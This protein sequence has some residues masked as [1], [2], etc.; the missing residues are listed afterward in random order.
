M[1]YLFAAVTLLSMKIIR[2]MVSKY[3]ENVRIKIMYIV[4]AL[5]TLCLV[6]LLCKK[7]YFAALM[8]LFAFVLPILVMTL[9]IYLYNLYLVIL[10]LALFF[11]LIPIMIKIVSKY[12]R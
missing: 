9:G 3:G 7:Q 8:I 12:K 5:L 11:V 6:G 1:T 4:I 10:G 2:V